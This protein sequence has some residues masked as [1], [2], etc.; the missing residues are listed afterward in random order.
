MSTSALPPLFPS[1]GS[2][3]SPDVMGQEAVVSRATPRVPEVGSRV[4]GQA[5]RSV[6]G[7]ERRASGRH[8]LGLRPADR[9]CW[10]GLGDPS[11]WLAGE[12]H[13]R[14]PP[15]CDGGGEAQPG[16]ADVHTP[17]ILGL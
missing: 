12:V 17:V 8:E 10:P 3:C 7:G 1:A 14:Q 6:G 15:P 9:Y 11:S 13:C 5:G 2:P 4:L 16:R